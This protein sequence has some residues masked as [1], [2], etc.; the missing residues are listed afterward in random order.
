M[1]RLASSRAAV[2]ISELA[3]TSTDSRPR[4]L[5]HWHTYVGPL[6]RDRETIIVEELVRVGQPGI[7]GARLGAGWKPHALLLQTSTHDERVPPRNDRTR[8][9][10]YT[11]QLIASSSDGQSSALHGCYVVD[12]RGF[13]SLIIRQAAKTLGEPSSA[14][15]HS[16]VVRWHSSR[17]AASAAVGG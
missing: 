7:D 3:T 14:V 5:A 9:E 6:M 15:L 11:C 8:V 13:P 17:A 2:T 10:H 16:W 1:T 4:S 12:L